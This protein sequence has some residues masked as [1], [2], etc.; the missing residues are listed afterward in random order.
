MRNV[1]EILLLIPM[2]TTA[3][4]HFSG[5]HLDPLSGI[6]S[7]AVV[8]GWRGFSEPCLRAACSWV[9]FPPNLPGDTSAPQEERWWRWALFMPK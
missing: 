1:R 3:D 4:E 8:S 6:L 9:L 5:L 2:K 7:R